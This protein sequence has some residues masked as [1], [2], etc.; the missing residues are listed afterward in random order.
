MYVFTN[1]AVRVIVGVINGIV[2]VAVVLPMIATVINRKR[3]R[4]RKS[5]FRR[6]YAPATLA[7]AV[8]ADV[9]VGNGICASAAEHRQ[10][11]SVIE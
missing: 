1:H 3:K 2:P 6:K 8:R 9:S 5:Q 10:I 4:M 11:V 7:R